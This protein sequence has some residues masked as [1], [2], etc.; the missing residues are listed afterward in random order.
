MIWASGISRIISFVSKDFTKFSNE[1][2]SMCGSNKAPYKHYKEI[3]TKSGKTSSVEDLK[4]GVD[5]PLVLWLLN[6][7]KI[8][9]TEYKK[10]K[11]DYDT[12]C[13][14][15]HPTDIQLSFHEVMKVFND[16]YKLFFVNT[17]L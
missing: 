15:A 2:T 7:N 14:C 4:T 11:A 6:Q 3:L 5:M 10:L 13:D 1:C 8:S 16:V 17:N 9:M 12:R